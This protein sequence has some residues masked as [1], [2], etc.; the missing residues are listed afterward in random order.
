MVLCHGV[1]LDARKSFLVRGLC[2]HGTTTE[3]QQNNN[4][5]TTEQQQQQ[6]QQNTRT[7]TYFTILLL[8]LFQDL[9]L[10]P[11]LLLSV[12]SV[13]AQSS[14]EATGHRCRSRPTRL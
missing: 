6:Q 14:G 12:G 8:L 3:Q 13:H 7:H 10:L 9:F 2:T 11:H 4:R 5:T 1:T